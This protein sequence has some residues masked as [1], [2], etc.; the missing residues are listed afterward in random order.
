LERA[1]VAALVPA[2]IGKLGY[3]NLVVDG[4]SGW[5]GLVA[6]ARLAN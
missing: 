4:V 6:R 1:L 5:G 3:G 2:G